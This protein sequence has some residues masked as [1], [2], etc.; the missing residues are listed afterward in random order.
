VIY[1][2]PFPYGLAA[3]IAALALGTGA[4]AMG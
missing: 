3:V 1:R 2:G 4:A